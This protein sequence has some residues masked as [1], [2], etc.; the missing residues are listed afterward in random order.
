MTPF[1]QGRL[2]GRRVSASIRS[3]CAACG[4][5]IGFV[6]DSDFRWR[7]DAGPASPLVFQPSI[8]WS[9]FRAPTIVN[10]Y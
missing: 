10:D 5:T 7:I 1:V 9:R 6:V 4:T 3:E 2:R 8:D